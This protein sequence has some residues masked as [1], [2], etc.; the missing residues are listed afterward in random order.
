MPEDLC[1]ENVCGGRAGTAGTKPASSSAGAQHGSEPEEPSG[2]DFGLLLR[3]AA[4]LLSRPRCREVAVPGA[5]ASVAYVGTSEL[6]LGDL[7]RLWQS[8]AEGWSGTCRKCGG[9]YVITGYGGSPLT[10]GGSG[11]GYC[12]EC[13]A[14]VRIPFHFGHAR[15]GVRAAAGRRAAQ[16]PEQPAVAP[17]PSSLAEWN[18]RAAVLAKTAAKTPRSARPPKK[19]KRIPSLHEVLVLLRLREHAGMA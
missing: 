8:G 5:W 13:G 17:R 10:G 2:Q 7:L 12:T 1:R 4:Y 15:E 19:E 14:R 18:G 9:R 3:N 6:R 11:W 16:F